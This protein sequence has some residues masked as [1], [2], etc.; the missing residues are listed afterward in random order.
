MVE[1]G[2]G[3]NRFWL[4]SQRSYSVKRFDAIP[5]SA[6]LLS[7]ASLQ[8]VMRKVTLITHCCRIVVAVLTCSFCAQGGVKA[9]KTPILVV[10]K[11]TQQ[12]FKNL[13]D[14]QGLTDVKELQRLLADNE[15]KAGTHRILVRPANLRLMTDPGFDLLDVEKYHK[16]EGVYNS[17]LYKQLCKKT[18]KEAAAK[19]KQNDEDDEDE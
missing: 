14:M 7:L 15:R 18:A 5:A 13:I 4:R 17:A 3:Y 16:K 19:K 9:N 12:F 8:H 10:S 2:S 1:F 11:E 6:G